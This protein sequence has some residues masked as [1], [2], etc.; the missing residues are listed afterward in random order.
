MKFSLLKYEKNKSPKK[1]DI[2]IIKENRKLKWKYIS[3]EKEIE[4]EKIVPDQVLLGLIEGAIKGPF[5]FLPAIKAE[6]SFTNDKRTIKKNNSLFN[7][8]I[9]K[10]KIKFII[11][12]RKNKSFWYFLERKK[13]IKEIKKIMFKG[14]WIK[15]KL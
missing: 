3:K 15:W 9:S 13:E 7:C 4:K 11:F 1:K 12:K 10:I 2:E 6:V 5:N 8:K 14:N